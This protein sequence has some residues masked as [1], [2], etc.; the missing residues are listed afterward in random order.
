MNYFVHKLPKSTKFSDITL[1]R[2]SPTGI[3]M[4]GIWISYMGILY[5]RV[6]RSFFRIMEK[7]NK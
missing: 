5:A 6:V 3:Y 4:I 7:K 1:K 2:G